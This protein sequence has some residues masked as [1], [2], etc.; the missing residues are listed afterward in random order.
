MSLNQV[1]NR[2]MLPLVHNIPVHV[3]AGGL[4]GLRRRELVVLVA[5]AGSKDVNIAYFVGVDGAGE[6]QLI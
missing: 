5:E 2:C 3:L 1:G 6:C 4:V